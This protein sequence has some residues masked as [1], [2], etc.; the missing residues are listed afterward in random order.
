MNFI[1]KL[2]V[3]LVLNGFSGWSKKSPDEILGKS[4]AEAGPEDLR[5]LSRSQVVSLFHA[6]DAPDF[7]SMKGEYSAEVLS[8]GPFKF[9]ADFYTHK[10]FGPGRWKGKAF[11][12]LLDSSGWGYNLFAVNG[13]KGGGGIARTCRMNT[14]HGLSYIDDKASFHLDYSPWNG[15]LNYTMHDEIRKINDRLFLGMGYMSAGGG[16]L[17]PAPFMLYGEANPWVGPD[18]KG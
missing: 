3:N 15:F 10:I 11:F 5:R 1:L 16:P 13:K 4:A 7:A 17:N 14:Y 2:L 6:A 12:P 8:V 9:V 18:K